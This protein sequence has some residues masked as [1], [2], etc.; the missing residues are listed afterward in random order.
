MIDSLGSLASGNYNIE[1]NVAL[2]VSTDF[3]E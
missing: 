3:K 1:A 2:N